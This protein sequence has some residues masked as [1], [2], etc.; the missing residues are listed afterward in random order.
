MR[1]VGLTLVLGIVC[2]FF[3]SMVMV[4]ALGWILISKAWFGICGQSMEGNRQSPRG[5]MVGR[6]DCGDSRE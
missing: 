3:F 1:T 6:D 5:R 4:P 2:T